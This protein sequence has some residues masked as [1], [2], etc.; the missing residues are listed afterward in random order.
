MMILSIKELDLAYFKNFRYA[1]CDSPHLD[2]YDELLKLLL[3]PIQLRLLIVINLVHRLPCHLLGRFHTERSH[4]ESSL[5]GWTC[6][7]SEVPGFSEW[8]VVEIIEF[9]LKYMY[10]S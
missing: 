4:M 9:L 7:A 8:I 3:P 6:D 1:L 10:R 5:R 2:Y